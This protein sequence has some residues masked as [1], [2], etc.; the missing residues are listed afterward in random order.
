MLK[1]KRK[2]KFKFENLEYRVGRL[3]VGPKDVI[4]LSTDLMLDKDQCLQLQARAKEWFPDNEVIVMTS[5]IKLGV[6]K[7]HDP[8]ADD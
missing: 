7:R 1:L 8:A 5:G 6:V 4:V 2:P 3:T